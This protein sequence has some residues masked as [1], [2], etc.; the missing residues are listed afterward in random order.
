ML[1]QEVEEVES[2]KI[3][4]EDDDVE[5][6]MMKD[7]LEICEQMGRPRNK[8]SMEEGRPIN[9]EKQMGRYQG[10]YVGE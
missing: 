4:V 3:M 2:D 1:N 10:S 6:D 9:E 5:I 7:D 8:E